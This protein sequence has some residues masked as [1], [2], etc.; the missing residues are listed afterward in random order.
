[1]CIRD[2]LSWNKQG[3]Y[4]LHQFSLSISDSD[5]INWYFPVVG[6]ESK[7]L[8]RRLN[9]DDATGSLFEWYGESGG[10]LKYYPLAKNA[11]WALSLIHI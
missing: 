1:M 6:N 5:K 8:A 3:W 11:V 10:Q 7:I 2:R 4:Q 9:G